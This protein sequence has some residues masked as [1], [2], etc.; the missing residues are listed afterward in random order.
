[1]LGV[2]LF[3]GGLVN[4]WFRIDADVGETDLREVGHETIIIF[5]AHRVILVLV[6]P[7]AADRD[8]QHGGSHDVHHV[9][10]LLVAASFSLL[11]GLLCGEGAGDEEACGGHGL[12]VL[13]PEQVTCYLQSREF[14]VR[15]V[16]IQGLDD[17]VPVTEGVL[18][19]LIEGI[20]I[21]FGKSYKVEPVAG[22]ALPITRTGQQFI[23]EVFI[24]FIEILRCSLYEVRGILLAGRQPG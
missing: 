10:E 20:A 7:G 24:S 11:L 16:V 15:H 17:E 19:V 13:G 9:V 4:P 5:L 2:E 14:V 18:A 1:M 23:E 6:A 8:A 21:A 12:Q 22:P 3:L